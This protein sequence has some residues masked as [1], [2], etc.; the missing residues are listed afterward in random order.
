MRQEKM[1]IATGVDVDDTGCPLDSDG[2]GVA[3]DLDRCPD[4][5]AGVKVDG[6]GCQLDGD[7]DGVVDASDRCPNTPAGVKVGPDGCPLDSDGDGVLDGDDDC[8]GTA[9]GTPENARGCAIEGVEVAGDVL[10]VAGELLFDLNKAEIRTE[11][12]SV[13]EQIA[14]WLARNEDVSLLVEGHTD[15]SGSAEHN[16]KLSERRAES[17]KAFLVAQGVA[18]TRV[19]TAGK[20]ESEPVVPNDSEANRQRNRRVE[21]EPLR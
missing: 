3:D 19:S 13:L 21:L 15:S 1:E 9:A 4:T 20:G 12:R 6:N 7:G 11:A 5:P 14:A 2:D 16:Q 18:A 10:H 17:V 8:P